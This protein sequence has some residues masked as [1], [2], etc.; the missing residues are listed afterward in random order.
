MAMGWKKSKRSKLWLTTEEITKPASHPFY[1]RVNEVQ[2]ECQFDRKV[3]QVLRAF[4][5]AGEG[6]PKHRAGRL[7]RTLL[8]GCCEGI[9]R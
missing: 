7:F 8:I 4:P 5:Q 1:A 9:S 2:E 3:E 6:S